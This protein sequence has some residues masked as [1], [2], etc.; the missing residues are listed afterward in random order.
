MSNPWMKKNPLLSLWLSGANSVAGAAQGRVRANAQ[1]QA[2]AATRQVT[3][4][5]MQAWLAPWAA[6]PPRRTRKRR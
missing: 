6:T 5:L 1:R 4:T 2:T 3:Q